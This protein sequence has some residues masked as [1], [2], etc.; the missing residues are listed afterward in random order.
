M[1]LEEL[2]FESRK[3][4]DPKGYGQIMSEALMHYYDHM[5]KG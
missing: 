2:Y 1:I 5:K 3:K 4:G